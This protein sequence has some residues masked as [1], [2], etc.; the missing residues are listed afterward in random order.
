MRDT[1]Q[2]I[3]KFAHEENLRDS[4]FF[5]SV[6]NKHVYDLL[7]RWPKWENNLINICG[8]NFSGKSHL[9]NIFIKK[10]LISCCDHHITKCNRGSSHIKD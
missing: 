9:V 2:K 8:E 10:F 1:D 6:S 4:D 7:N 5:V 3:I